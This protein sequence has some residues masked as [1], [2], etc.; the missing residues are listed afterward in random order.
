MIWGKTKGRRRKKA[1]SL[2]NQPSSHVIDYSDGLYC[3]PLSLPLS[4]P[5][6]VQARKHAS[7]QT[8]R[9]LRPMWL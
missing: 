2:I 3:P 7:R 4:L 6:W 9:T 1:N 8:W 5:L